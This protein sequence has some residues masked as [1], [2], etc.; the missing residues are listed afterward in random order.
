MQKLL[1]VSFEQFGYHTDNFNY[2]FY[3]RE[4]FKICLMCFDEGL[5][6]INLE[7]VKVIY[8]PNIKNKLIRRVVFNSLLLCKIIAFNPEVIFLRYFR[9]CS[10][11]RK[12][13]K[14]KRMIVD[15][16]TACVDKN[17]NTRNEYNKTMSMEC[18]KFDYISVISEGLI[19]KLRL[20]REKTFVLPLGGKKLA[21]NFEEVGKSL[22]LIYVGV[23]DERKIDTTIR[24]FNKFSEIY[25]QEH[26]YTII[27][28][29]NDLQVE[30]DILK[31]IKRNKF[32]NVKYLGRIPNEELG[33][34]FSQNNVGISYIPMTDFFEH[35]PPTKT[36]EYLMNGL[37]T[38]AT[39][40]Y[41]NKKIINKSNGIIIEDNEDSVYRA[42]EESLKMLPIINRDEIIKSIEKYS[43]ENICNNFEKKIVD[44]INS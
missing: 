7:N 14:N 1:I 22:S 9:S 44:I 12:I 25:G 20:K 6:R 15:I 36:Y 23:F 18:N 3:L 29:A 10:I 27:G 38:L 19:D 2:A 24:A 8:I 40:T 21:S 28:F 31:E 17:E 30:G 33:K 32:N 42:L 26:T 5:P 34:Y 13:F 39:G 35:Q 37:F 11:F 41:E 4:K 16:R 43:W